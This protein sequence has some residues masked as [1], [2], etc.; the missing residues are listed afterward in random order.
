MKQLI[1]IVLTSFILLSCSNNKTISVDNETNQIESIKQKIIPILNGAW[2]LTD[3]IKAIEENQSP[4]KASDKLRGVV[5][6]IIEA[7]IKSDSI[8]VGASLN[9][10]EGYSFTT[11]FITGET[12]NSLKTNITD[13]NDKN[14]YYEIGYEAVDNDIVLVL[15]HYNKVNKLIDKK[16]FTKVADKA[17]SRDVEWGLQYIVN[18]KLF[19][20]NYLFIDSTNTAIEVNMKSDG[21]LTNHPNLKTYYV[22]TDFTMDP[23]TAI[24]GIIF[25]LNEKNSKWFTFKI[26]KDTTYL[27]PV[28][29]NEEGEFSRLDKVQ[30]TLIKK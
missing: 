10:H 30:Y 23:E 19:S 2:V 22:S 16:M 7:E 8:E 12:P 28:I 17:Q 14:N 11:Y 13:Y 4:L 3:Y 1:C 26:N 20:G 24:D 9:N 5:T 15:Y 27:Y 29:K 25:N 18:E 6:M 21:S